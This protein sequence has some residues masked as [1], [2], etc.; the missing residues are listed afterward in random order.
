MS[1]WDGDML[2]NVAY[3]KIRSISDGNFQGCYASNKAEKFKFRRLSQG[4]ESCAQA[5]ATKLR[6]E[7]QEIFK[8]YKALEKE[9]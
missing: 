4:I 1:S 5:Q 8:I 6:K 3:K 7:E 2:Y 9:K